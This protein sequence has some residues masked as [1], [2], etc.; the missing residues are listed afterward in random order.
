[1]WLP[2]TEDGKFL[3]EEEEKNCYFTENSSEDVVEFLPT[4]CAMCMQKD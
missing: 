3:D 4:A 1:M 2:R